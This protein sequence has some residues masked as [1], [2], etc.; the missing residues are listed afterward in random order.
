MATAATTYTF[1]AGTTIL[2]SQAN[3]NFNDVISFLNGEV[4]HKDGSVAFTAVPSGPATDPTTDNQLARKAYVDGL[5]KARPK[6]PNATLNGRSGNING[7]TTQLIVQAGSTVGTTS[8]GGDLTIT[9]PSAFP[10]GL[11]SCM[12]V[13]GD[14]VA[15]GDF[16]PQLRSST[17][18]SVVARVVNMAGAVVAST[19]VRIDW[20]AIGW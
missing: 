2:A 9:F 8:L 15:V 14:P 13:N 4:I 16:L 20:I 3:T 7:S 5:V 10:T 19:S 17:L 6:A 11:L 12:L 18:S 1:T